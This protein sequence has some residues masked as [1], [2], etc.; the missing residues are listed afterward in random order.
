MKLGFNIVSVWFGFIMVI[1][2]VCGA[3]TLIFTDYL[4]DNLYGNKRTF[5]IVL[6]LAYSVY[7]SIRIYQ[8]LKKNQHEA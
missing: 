4:L 6:L 2:L 7:R 3:F 5:F 8:V 1:G